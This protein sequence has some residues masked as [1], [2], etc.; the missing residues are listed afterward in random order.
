MEQAI[1]MTRPVY[2]FSAGVAN[3]VTRVPLASCDCHLHV[4]DNTHP[5]ASGAKLNPPT[6]TVED[7]R[8]IQA[9]MGTSRAV[10]VTPSTY[11]AD[12]T[13]MLNGL[14]QL[15]AQ[16]RGVAVIDGDESEAQLHAL[17]AAGVRGVR[18]NLSLG[19]TN[20]VASIEHIAHR[21]AP[22]GWHLQLLMPIEQLVALSPVLERLPTA[23]VF[24][25]F[26][27]IT[28]SQC[29][30]H[31]AHHWLRA[32]MARGKAWLKLS[33]GCL[34]S[35]TASVEDVGLD[36]LARS[37]IDAAPERV[38]WGSDWP[39]ATASAGLQPMPDD[40]RQIDRLAQWAGDAPQLQRILVSN[41]ARLYDFPSQPPG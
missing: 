24:D 22:L 25:H 21:I 31:P 34:V 2:P 17:Q 4:Y 38:V 16:G 11:G 8:R 6:A 15:G 27:R 28:P 26:A 39:H 33:G 19:A 14:A 23:M 13:V 18:I 1:D 5:I 37:F 10:L 41:P 7:Y 3:A 36:D 12:N 30:K 20:D 32:M 40:A 29:M 35:P 9:R